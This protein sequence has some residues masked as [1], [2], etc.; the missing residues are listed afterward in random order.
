MPTGLA[1]GIAQL[2]YIDPT[3]AQ[4]LYD[5]AYR[6]GPLGQS[7]GPRVNAG[8]FATYAG[9]RVMLGVATICAS[10]AGSLILYEVTLAN[11][12]GKLRFDTQ[13]YGS[14]HFL[15]EV[16][17]QTYHALGKAGSM[18]LYQA[19]AGELAGASE[20]YFLNTLIIPLRNPGAAS[21]FANSATDAGCQ[22][23]NCF[24]AAVRVIIN[25]L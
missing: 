8:N 13:M 22:F 4:E 25:G 21:Q 3:I 18:R 11:G 5:H 12:A 2:S 17:G 14:D 1:G 6:A 20:A 24:T 7:S 16:E 10:A 23:G 15:F 9:T 19:G